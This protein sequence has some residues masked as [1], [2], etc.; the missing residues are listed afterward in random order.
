MLLHSIPEGELKVKA[1]FVMDIH[2]RSYLQY[3][4]RS[5]FYSY[6]EILNCPMDEITLS[7]LSITTAAQ[8]AIV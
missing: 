7:M 8:S 2:I 3:I 1:N 4:Y 6:I 5:L